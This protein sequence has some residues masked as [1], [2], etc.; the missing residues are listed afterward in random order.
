[1]KKFYFLLS[2]FFLTVILIGCSNND[3]AVTPQPTAYD[4]ASFSKGG[5]MF[6]KFWSTES[7]FNQSDPNI[8]IFNSKSDFFRCKQ[9]HGWDNLG[10]N[11]SYIGRGPNANRPN[12]ADL[13][14]YSIIQ[15]KTPQELF[16]AMKSTVNRRDISFDFATYVSSDP[17]NDGHK[18]PNYA[19]LLTDSQIWD[20]VKF[21][22]S[23]AFDVT[24]LYD[25]VYSGVY[26]TGTASFSNIGKDGNAANGNTTYSNNCTSCHGSNGT[27]ILVE[28][29]TVGKFT[30]SKPNEVQHKV[31]YG[32]L[33]SSMTG[34]FDMTITQMKDLYKALSD[35]VAFPNSQ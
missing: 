1:M 15:S 5:I 22:K 10:R 9:C 6:D 17:N 27:L 7:G 32:Q 16:D 24:Q 35:T 26:P 18:M 20:M 4:L 3:N 29:M 13:N 11:G 12:V 34:K 14:L 30:R 25:A 8:T 28:G 21:M 33:G 31:K 2:L 23:A 19:Q